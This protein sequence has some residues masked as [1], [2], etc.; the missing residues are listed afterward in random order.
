MKNNL[1]RAMASAIVALS[2]LFAFMPSALAQTSNPVDMTISGGMT[3]FSGTSE[4]TQLFLDRD[5]ARRIT[6]F[7][8]R[9][10]VDPGFPI[11]YNDPP[12]AI[13]LQAQPS[14]PAIAS[15]PAAEPQIEK[16]SLVP[17]AKTVYIKHFPVSRYEQVRSTLRGVVTYGT[18]NPY[19]DGA[20]VCD[21]PNT[22]IRYRW[23]SVFMA[24]NCGANAPDADAATFATEKLLK[25]LGRETKAAPDMMTKI[26]R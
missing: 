10:V 2:A 1:Y 11:W 19:I 16:L 3:R 26:P 18:V 23:R 24:Y 7:W 17:F 25:A 9:V 5:E 12:P 15:L 22:T 14:A 21:G 4:K 20:V 8:V 13:V 6:H